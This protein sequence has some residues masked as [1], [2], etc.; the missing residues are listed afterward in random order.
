MNNAWGF[1]KSQFGGDQ[2]VDTQDSLNLSKED[3]YWARGLGFR[4]GLLEDK[5]HIKIE[6]VDTS[7]SGVKTAQIIQGLRS[8][9]RDKCLKAKGKYLVRTSG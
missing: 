2:V 4:D 7:R 1:K 5:D 6:T 3:E 9:F 8:D